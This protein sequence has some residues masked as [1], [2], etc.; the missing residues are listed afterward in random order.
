MKQPAV[1]ILTNANNKV[2]YIGV[3]SSLPQRVYQHKEKS[4]KGFTSRYNCDKLVYYEL[5]E[6]M[7]DAITRER[8]IKKWKRE[9]KIE[10][11]TKMNSEWRD[12]FE[13]IA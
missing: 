6:N 7:Y 11:I 4:I 3:T 8:Q 12:L 9:W 2:L 13:D 10:L 1:Y 5:W